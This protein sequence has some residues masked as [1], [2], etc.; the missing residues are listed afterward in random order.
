MKAML[1]T[2]VAMP[3]QACQRAQSHLEDKFLNIRLKKVG[4]T[5]SFNDWKMLS[6][7]VEGGFLTMTDMGFDSC[8]EE[9]DPSSVSSSLVNYEGKMMFK[10]IFIMMLNSK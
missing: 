1:F 5:K 8:A 6:I 4:K 3:G 9:D 10:Y 2:I 7:S